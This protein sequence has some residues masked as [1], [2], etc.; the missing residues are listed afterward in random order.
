MTKKILC[1]DDEKDLL[2]S[3]DVSL[4]HLDHD[5]EFIAVTSGEQC[6]EYLNRIDADDYPDLILL[7]IMMPEMNGW[8]TY[9]A[10]RDNPEWR[11]IPI[12]I[13][14]ALTD[15][16][17]EIASTILGDGIIKKPIESSDLIEKIDDILQS[18]E[19]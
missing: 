4:K 9:D 6:I 3:M 10:I 11:T 19:K 5:Y 8:D 2:Y 16:I 13:F 17:P 14:T 15:N 12:V 18:L 1:V 7:D